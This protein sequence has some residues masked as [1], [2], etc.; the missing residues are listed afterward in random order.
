[1][2]WKKG[3]FHEQN[4]VTQNFS[5]ASAHKSERVKLFKPNTT[6]ICDQID[7]KLYNRWVRLSHVPTVHLPLFILLLQAHAPV[8][9]KVCLNLISNLLFVFITND[10]LNFQF[11]IT[12]KEHE[13]GDYAE[14]YIPDLELK[15]LQEEYKQ[16]DNPVV[17]RNL[18]W[19]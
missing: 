3:K 2:P 15:Q 17:R 7:L 6:T 8:G 18:G 11:K 13:S 16:L 1:M 10:S 9:V 19:E 12:I 5:F 4:N 14:R